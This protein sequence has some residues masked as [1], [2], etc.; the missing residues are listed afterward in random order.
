MSAPVAVLGLGAMGLAMAQCLVKVMPV[1]GFDVVPDRLALAEADG[2]VPEASPA[3]AADGVEVVVV[4]VRDGAQLHAVV[5]GEGGAAETMAAGSVLIVTSTVGAQAVRDVA[6]ALEP[7]G[8]HVVD[9]PVSGGPVRAAAGDLLLMV[10]AGPKALAIARPVLEAL[11]STLAFPGD[12]GAGQDLKTVNQLLCG[13]HTA[14]ANEALALAHAMGLDL[15]AVLETLGKGPRPRSC[16]PTAGP[17]SSS[18]YAATDPPSA[19]AST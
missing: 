15:D 3:A 4:S 12:V 5:Q 1:R 14:A 17:A 2:V 10:G 16:S 11:A 13:I 8:V 19:R 18:S 6:A 7:R 9:A